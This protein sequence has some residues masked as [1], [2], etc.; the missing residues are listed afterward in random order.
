MTQIKEFENRH[1]KLRVTIATMDLCYQLSNVKSMSRGYSGPD[2]YA[3][4]ILPDR[5]QALTAVV[6]ILLQLSVMDVYP[7]SPVFIPRTETD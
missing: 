6:K 7:P 2:V 4:S 3:L 5:L 1:V